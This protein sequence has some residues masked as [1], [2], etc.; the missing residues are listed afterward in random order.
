MQWHMQS[1]NITTIIRVKVDFTLSEL[2]ST[3]A[4]TWKCHVDDS[5]KG[6]YDMIIGKYLFTELILSLKFSDHIIEADDGPFKGSTTP[7]VYFGTY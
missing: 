7:M 5:A 1:G 3:N 2:I 6:R 4:V